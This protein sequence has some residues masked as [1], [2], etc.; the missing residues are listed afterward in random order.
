MVAGLAAI[1][2]ASVFGMQLVLMV[3]SRL[4]GV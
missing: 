4:S 2:L 1:A 3:I